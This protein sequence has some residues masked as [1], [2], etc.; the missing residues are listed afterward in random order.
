MTLR[1][2]KPAEFPWF[3][4]EGFT[5]CL[6]LTEDGVAWSSGHTAAA[7]DAAVGKM[8]V[9]GTMEQQARIAYRKVLTIIEAAGLGPDDVV[10]VTENVTVAGLADYAAAAAVREEVFGAHRPT[11]TTVVVERLVRSAAL[12]EVELHAMPGGGAELLAASEPREAGTWVSSPVREGHDGTVHLPTMVP[13][14]ASGDVVSPGDF[15]G[16]YAYCLDR[17]DALLR[18]AGLSL[19]NAVTT[20]DYST[21]AT[22][23]V[24]RK[25]HRVRK[26][27]LGGAGVYPGA[28]GILMSRLHHPE[29]LVAIDVTASRHPLELVNPGWS[30]YDTLTYA[31][32][33]RAGRTLFMSGFA[34][35][36]METQQ[37]LHP[38]DLRAQAEETY[39]AILH[40][41]THAG[42]GPAD[43]LSTIEFCV[44]SALPDYRVVAPVRERLLSPPWPASTGAICK[45]L[46]RP[47]FLLEVFPTALYP[48]EA[49]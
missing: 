9:S 31:P 8:T 46:L 47:E 49:S 30:R 33:V 16:Q 27:R 15:A 39:G 18:E 12:L 29:A 17:A 13:I 19:D 4:Y 48:E 24:Y 43:L 11:V 2:I 20:Y 40:L 23:E 3:P 21:P 22:R 34:A 38:G 26:E 28:G 10:H 37:A 14:D 35:L 32:G 7:H 36:D 44:E 41:L 42:L 25:S 1:A 45:E 5:F 6:G